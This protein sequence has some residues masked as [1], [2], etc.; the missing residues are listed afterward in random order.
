M[1]VVSSNATCVTTIPRTVPRTCPPHQYRYFLNNSFESA[2]RREGGGRGLYLVT[3]SL[4]VGCGYKDIKIK[5]VPGTGT[6]KYIFNVDVPLIGASIAIRTHLNLTFTAGHLHK[7]FNLTLL[8]TWHDTAI[9]LSK[10]I[11]TPT[12]LRL[13]IS[14]EQSGTI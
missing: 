11:N 13:Y 5:A 1:S 9:P 10:D 14:V 3:A 8:A 4:S 2:E 7:N 12:V 6:S